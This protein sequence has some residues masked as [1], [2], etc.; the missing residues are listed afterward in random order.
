M[1]D[2]KGMYLVHLNFHFHMLI[3]KDKLDWEL[4]GYNDNCQTIVGMYTEC[5]ICL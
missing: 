4:Q 3:L 1:K 5:S 2:V